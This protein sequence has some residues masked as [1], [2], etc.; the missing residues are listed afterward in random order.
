M[1]NKSWSL[2]FNTR[3]TQAQILHG[4]FLVLPLYPVVKRY[5]GIKYRLCS[6]WFAK[7]DLVLFIPFLVHVIFGTRSC[8]TVLWG[9]LQMCD[10]WSPCLSP[11]RTTIEGMQHREAIWFNFFRFFFIVWVFQRWYYIFS[12]KNHYYSKEFTDSSIYR[13]VL[14]SGWMLQM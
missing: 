1:R 12:E 14:W 8:C 9:W 5:C 6:Q 13:Q 2:L 10:L 3:W 11:P 4:M 7:F